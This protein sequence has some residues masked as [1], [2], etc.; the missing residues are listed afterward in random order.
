MKL[1][2]EAVSQPKFVASRGIE[3]GGVDWAEDISSWATGDSSI[4][5]QISFMKIA[6]VE[7]YCLSLLEVN[8]TEATQAF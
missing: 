4:I 2:L 1:K 7:T 6:R 5:R 3:I 8:L